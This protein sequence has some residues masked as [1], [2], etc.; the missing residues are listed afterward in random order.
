MMLS[1]FLLKIEKYLSMKYFFLSS[2]DS[3]DT[4]NLE[5]SFLSVHDSLQKYSRDETKAGNFLFTFFF[6][7]QPFSVSQ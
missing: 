6:N 5:T 3:M 7:T 4:K 1:L 2:N